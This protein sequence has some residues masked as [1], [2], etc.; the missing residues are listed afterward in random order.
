MV[1]EADVQDQ[2][3]RDSTGNT[4]RGKRGAEGKKDSVSGDSVISDP[5]TVAGGVSADN[6]VRSG[7][8]E[9]SERDARDSEQSGSV[10]DSE[11][12][13]SDDGQGDTESPMG[14]IP[15]DDGTDQ[16]IVA[17]NHP[18]ARREL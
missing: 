3:R 9:V 13:L 17:A 18:K 15:E 6:E 1:G 4:G 5:S 16:R 14:A 2:G 10:G 7:E 8:S 12:G 11:I